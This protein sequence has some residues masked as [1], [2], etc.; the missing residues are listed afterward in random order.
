MSSAYLHS[1]NREPP[2]P[3]YVGLTIHARTRKREL[4]ET[5]L[6]LGLSI[7]Y[8]RVMAISTAIGNSVCEQY[9]LE[10]AICPLNLRQGLFTTAAID[11][12]DHNPSSATARYSFH[13]TG[14]GISLFQHSSSRH[15]GT[16]RREQFVIEHTSTKLT[17]VA[18]VLH[19]SALTVLP[20][21]DAPIP[22][23]DGPLKGDGQHFRQALQEEFRWL[24][25]MEQTYREDINKDSNISWAA[26]HASQQPVQDR[27]PAIAALLPLFLED[28]KSAAMIKHSMDQIK[29]A[30]EKLNPGQY[31]L[32]PWTSPSTQSPNR[33][34]GNGLQNTGK[35]F[36]SWCLEGYT[37]R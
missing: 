36:L 2:L 22:K 30:V 13:G 33:Y 15:L 24:E 34:S 3:V 29:R 19:C 8:D 25:I 18:R 7:S 23:V 10:Q 6:D 16:D 35:M 11:N 17:R 32:S 1:R 27:P 14:T 12:I 26:Y 37:L 31:Q 28:S 21:K 4:V 20:S 5:M 9:R